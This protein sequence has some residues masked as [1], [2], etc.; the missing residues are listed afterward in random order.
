MM[1]KNSI[2]R[3]V[4]LILLGFGLF[5]IIASILAFIFLVLTGHWRDHISQ[6][7]TLAFWLT[8]PAT[9]LVWEKYF[10]KKHFS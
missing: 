7:V 6:I 9:Y 2:G 8:L 3:A 4:S 10:Q 1:S 5:H